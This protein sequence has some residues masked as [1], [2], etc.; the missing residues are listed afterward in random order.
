VK[1][2]NAAKG[3]MGWELG[4]CG[5]FFEFCERLAECRLRR[6][7]K[8]V[9]IL[10]DSDFIGVFADF[11]FGPVST[12][13]FRL[14]RRLRDAFQAFDYTGVMP[15]TARERRGFGADTSGLTRSSGQAQ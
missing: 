4:A 6:L 9:A 5:F 8:R 3:L 1:D 7:D 2:R 11:G 12:S 10:K 15:A 14:N 13:G